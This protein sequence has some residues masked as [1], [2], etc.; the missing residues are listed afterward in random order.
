MFFWSISAFACESN[1][2]QC[3]TSTQTVLNL[4]SDALLFYLLLFDGQEKH[5]KIEVSEEVQRGGATLYIISVFSP[6]SKDDIT[7][8]MPLYERTT[9]PFKCH[10][11]MT[12][13]PHKIHATPGHPS[14]SAPWCSERPVVTLLLLLKIVLVFSSFFWSFLSHNSLYFTAK[15]LENKTSV[16][17][18]LTLT[19]FF[20]FSD[21]DE[22]EWRMT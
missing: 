22:C 21:P 14:S 1:K 8:K 13:F 20:S 17:S 4:W 5:L 19:F 18:C 9:F 3:V 7:L 2:I 6:K 15:L 10:L 12:S 11:V 16:A